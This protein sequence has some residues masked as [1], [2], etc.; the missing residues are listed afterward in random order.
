M[1]SLQKA[2]GGDALLLMYR[3]PG[4]NSDTST[5]TEYHYVNIDCAEKSK[6]L[7]EKNIDNVYGSDPE[8]MLI[9]VSG[10]RVA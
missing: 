7:R 6:S 1:E 9:T 5:E 10:R 8:R 2:N 3:G 4:N